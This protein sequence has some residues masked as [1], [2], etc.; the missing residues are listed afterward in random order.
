MN[1]NNPD[2][3]RF[4]IDFPKTMSKCKNI[5]IREEAIKKV[6]TFTNLGSITSKTDR[7]HQSLNRKSYKC[8]HQLKSAFEIQKDIFTPS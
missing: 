5:K 2:C 7:T 4:G 6:E 8:I 3:R 1:P